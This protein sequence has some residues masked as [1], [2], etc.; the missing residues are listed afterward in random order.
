[1]GY[2]GLRWAPLYHQRTSFPIVINENAD[3]QI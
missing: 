1:M 2:H 3:K